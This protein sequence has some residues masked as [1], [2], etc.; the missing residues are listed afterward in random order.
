VESAAGRRA[1]AVNLPSWES[2]TALMPLEE[3]EQL[4]VT[5][6]DSFADP[7]VPTEQLSRH[8]SLAALEHEQKIWRWV[9]LAVWTV[10]LMEI[11]LSGWLTRAVP[12]AQGEQS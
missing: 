4:G 2:R 3:L 9:M 11:G 7:V 12:V 10:L 5:V 1:F 6:K 8:R